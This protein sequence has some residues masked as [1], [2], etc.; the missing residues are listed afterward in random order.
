MRILL[1]MF[2]GMDE[3]AMKAAMKKLGMQQQPIDAEEVVIK[4]QGS[5]TEIVLAHPAVTKVTMMGQE[6][7]QVVGEY[8]ERP[9]QS[10]QQPQLF[11]EEDVRTVIGQTGAPEAE[12]K[13]A[14]AKVNGDLAAAILLL[15]EKNAD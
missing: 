9:S 1:A 10:R 12:A 11:N 3:R 13:A 2:P 5:A 7:F 6:T 8:S 4:L 15:S 14:L